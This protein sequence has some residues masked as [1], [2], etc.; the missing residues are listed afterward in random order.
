MSVERT[1]TRWI[2]RSSFNPTF[3]FLQTRKRNVESDA[4]I[5]H[6]TSHT[7]RTSQMSAPFVTLCFGISFGSLKN[8]A[9]IIYAIKING[10]ANAW[11]E[12]DADEVTMTDTNDYAQHS[13]ASMLVVSKLNDLS[14][15]RGSKVMRCDADGVYYPIPRSL[16]TLTTFHRIILHSILSSLPLFTV[17]SSF[18][19]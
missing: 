3:Q 16:N 8:S 4:M 10:N 19:N 12:T 17:L 6:G 15:R 2:S 14:I 5:I 11:D 1:S 18:V 13:R 9:I 7:D